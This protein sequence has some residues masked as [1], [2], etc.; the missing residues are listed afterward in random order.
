MH[1]NLEFRKD[2][3]IRNQLQVLLIKKVLGEKPDH[4]LVNNFVEENR[5]VISEII[6]DDDNGIAQLAE[7]GHLAEAAELAFKIFE[8][9]HLTNA[10]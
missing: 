2:T 8:S 5:S 6:D 1:E 10:A 4:D 9:R 3:A 7:D